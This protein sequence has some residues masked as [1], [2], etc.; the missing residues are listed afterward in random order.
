[1]KKWLVALVMGLVFCLAC[2]AALADGKTLP[3]AGSVETPRIVEKGQKATI[4]TPTGS[5]YEAIKLVIKDTDGWPVTQTEIKSVSAASNGKL[6]FTVNT[7]NTTFT[8][9]HLYY[10][11]LFALPTANSDQAEWDLFWN[12]VLTVVPQNASGLQIYMNKTT[13]KTG[14]DLF[15]TAYDPNAENVWIVMDGEPFQSRPGNNI[16][17]IQRYDETG[18]HTVSAISIDANGNK[19]SGQQNTINVIQNDSP[20]LYSANETPVTF[21]MGNETKSLELFPETVTAGTDIVYTIHRV[22]KDIG[23]DE[24]GLDEQIWYDSWLDDRTDWESSVELPCFQKRYEPEVG[25]GPLLNDG[26]GDQTITIKSNRLIAG[27]TYQLNVEIRASGCTTV[28]YSKEF[29]VLP[30]NMNNQDI[31]LKF[32]GDNAN[33]DVIEMPVFGDF[34]LVASAPGASIIRFWNG[35]NFDYRPGGEDVN[36][37]HKTWRT[38]KYQY[39][40][41][42]YY[43]N[44]GE[45]PWDQLDWDPARISN[46][47]TV[48]AVKDAQ[49]QPV[50]P[51][52]SS[53]S[54]TVTRG[55]YYTVTLTNTDELNQS[56]VYVGANVYNGNDIENHFERTGDTIMVPT[57]DLWPGYYILEVYTETTG[58][59]YM[60][61][62][63]TFR[64]VADQSTPD[65]KFM[66]T[67][68]V[69]VVNGERT[70][71]SYENYGVTFFAPDKEG[72][73]RYYRFFDGQNW[74]EDNWFDRSI[75]LDTELD[76]GTWEIYAEAVYEPEQEGKNEIRIE[77]DHIQIKA[78][79]RGD[80]G[81]KLS[82]PGSYVKG[83]NGYTVSIVKENETTFNPSLYAD[84]YWEVVFEEVN[85]EGYMAFRRDNGGQLQDSFTFSD[86]QFEAGKTYKVRLHLNV[87]GYNSVDDEV[88]FVVVDSNAV[89]QQKLELSVE[90]NKGTATFPANTDFNVKVTKSDDITAVRVLNGDNWNIWT[91]DDLER[92][93]SFGYG[94]YGIVAQGTTAE[95]VWEKDG[96][97]WGSFDWNDVNWSVISNTVTVRITAPNGKLG[98]PTL[99]LDKTR[100]TRGGT[101]AATVNKIDNSEWYDLHI[102]P[103]DERGN[104]QG[105]WV[106]DAHMD[107]TGTGTIGF[108]VPTYHME[109]GTYVVWVDNNGTGYQ[110]NGSNRVIIQVEEGSQAPTPILE[111]PES[112]STNQKIEFYGFVPDADDVWVDVRKQGESGWRDYW[113]NDGNHGT[114]EFNQP[115]GGTYIFKLYGHVNGQEVLAAGPVR[116]EV[117][118][119]SGDLSAATIT[120]SPNVITLTENGS[121][122]VVSGTFVKD[123]H[124]EWYQVRLV[125]CGPN[126]NWDEDEIRND[127]RDGENISTTFTFDG[128]DFKRGAGVYEVQVIGGATG[129]NGTGCSERIL[130]IEA[131]QNAITLSVN[132]EGGNLNAWPSSKNLRITVH[133]PNSSAIRVWDDNSWDY[134]DSNNMDNGDYIF[135]YNYNDAGTYALVAQASYD[136]VDWNNVDWDKF[137][138]EAMGWTATSNQVDVTIVA[139]GQLAQPVYSM[140]PAAVP[141]GNLVITIPNP[142]QDQWYGVELRNQDGWKVIDYQDPDEG[143]GTK[144]TL[145]IPQDTEPGTYLAWIWTDAE[146]KVGCS[147]EVPIIIDKLAGVSTFR[148]PAKL[149]QVESDAFDNVHMD[150]VILQGNNPDI[151]LSFLSGKGVKYVVT[152]S[153]I[154][155]PRNCYFDVI[156][157]AQYNVIK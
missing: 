89:N 57:A 4:S 134:K 131:V 70:V 143:T 84:E 135:E 59:G 41:Q 141:G 49:L 110:G 101:I 51:E 40:I 111:L 34:D 144:F 132:A 80:S 155:V 27:H 71:E 104:E 63:H 113:D 2:Y 73:S 60:M 149:A 18:S 15:I 19:T 6:S 92:Y 150:V 125:Y 119:D 29:V 118:A 139:N 52:Y 105:E 86:D 1:M 13:V 126:G 94:I 123:A 23:N 8:A 47:L 88:C 109:P 22:T 114:W 9:G 44:I 102:S 30:A 152:D 54:D 26:T 24:Q 72:Y 156:T 42:A 96:F 69:P 76:P 117:K 148:L 50:K 74:W 107:S 90:G 5:G 147:V 16:T 133:A 87:R 97:D 64:V 39:F 151:D 28:R 154:T 11:E 61:N 65:D 142:I 79:S 103:C 153:S 145:H 58:A 129:Y 56:G 48:N 32:T 17:W 106:Y 38:G 55:E 137:D 3:N 93:W 81:I 62:P 31:T 37:S 100:I 12:S 35:E 67:T 36:I 21:T 77:S 130:A 20:A 95:A 136:N 140:T 138:W 121:N 122:S 10:T 68:T 53:L 46:I 108:T 85:G 128:T 99:T 33:K 14:Y 43:G 112:I 116:M 115:F 75:T 157:N 127:Y 45:T 82:A 66:I 7:G 98:A 146:G 124:A 120:L 91:G 25:H 83:G 78:T